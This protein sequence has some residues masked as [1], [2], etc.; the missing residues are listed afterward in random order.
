MS[1]ESLFELNLLRVVLFRVLRMLPGKRKMPGG[2]DQQRRIRTQRR[3]VRDARAVRETRRVE[4]LES[5]P[6]RGQVVQTSSLGP[7]VE[8]MPV[9]GIFTARDFATVI[10]GVLQHF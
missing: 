8:P 2:V 4:E 9:V 3:V 10:I 6:V 5:A 7:S 1:L